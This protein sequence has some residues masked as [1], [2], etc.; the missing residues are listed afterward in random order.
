MS[1]SLHL[2]YSKVGLENLAAALGVNSA[3]LYVSPVNQRLELSEVGLHDKD[4]SYEE[5]LEEES[6]G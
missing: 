6:A 4:D 3:F 2:P 5:E 1:K